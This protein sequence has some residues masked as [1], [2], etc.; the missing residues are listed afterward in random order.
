MELG[1]S[2][3]ILRRNGITDSQPLI[4]TTDRSRIA[5]SRAAA[6][7]RGG[8]RHTCH[9]RGRRRP[10][11]NETER[12]A[13]IREWSGL[14]ASLGTDG[15]AAPGWGT[16]RLDPITLIVLGFG[17]LDSEG[18]RAVSFPIAANPGGA[19]GLTIH[20]QSLVGTAPRFTNLETVVFSDL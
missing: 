16:L 3:P 18:R 12:A 6:P 11:R 13:W 17:F 15:I 4:R 14:G 10:G 20:S 8:S 19:A 7:E 9:E 5:A 2:A 1:S